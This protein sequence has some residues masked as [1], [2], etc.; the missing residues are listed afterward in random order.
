MSDS[1]A[2]SIFSYRQGLQ[3]NT[4]WC[5]PVTWLTTGSAAVIV[6]NNPC[7]LLY[8]W[9]FA[10]SPHNHN[11]APGRPNELCVTSLISP[12]IPAALPAT[13]WPWHLNRH[14]LPHVHR[15]LTCHL[16]LPSPVTPAPPH[17][18]RPPPPLPLPGPYR[19]P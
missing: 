4:N 13:T 17:P 15:L 9:P 16:P 3:S 14:P 10:V 7:F 8:I 5:R 6:S 1:V 12:C 2:F 11:P 18:G 19:A